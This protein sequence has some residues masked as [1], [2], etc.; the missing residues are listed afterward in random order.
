MDVESDFCV[1]G[2]GP[3]GMTLALLLLRSGGR[4]VVVER[5][6]S[7]D[8]EFRG[9]ILQPG[10]LRLLSE[11]GVLDDARE[12]GCHEHDGFLL[13]SH[14]K[15]L[16]ESDYRRLAPPFNC[17]LSIPQRNILEAL[18]A[19]CE[20]YDSFRYLAGA[21]AR[22]LLMDGQRVRGVVTDGPDG[23]HVVRAHVLIGADGRYSKIRQLA[24]ID[25]ARLDVFDQDIMWF[26]LSDPGHA[27]RHVT[28]FSENGNPAI[29]Y[30]SVP[31]SVQCGWTL[32]HGG[33]SEV[34]GK[35][36]DHI[37]DRLRAA[38]PSYADLIESQVTS[39]RDL[40]LLDV[41][42]GSAAAWV[43]D[44]L[45]LIGDSAHTHSPIGAQGINLAI[46]DAVVLHPLLMAS[47]REG[48]A[49]AAFLG[50]F[51][52]LR[53]RDI[54]RLT[55]IQVAQSRGMLAAGGVAARI[56]PLAAT[57]VT[58]TP[59]YRRMLDLIAFGNRRITVAADLFTATSLAAADLLAQ[60]PP[61]H[62]PVP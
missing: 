18:H 39:L 15:V 54:A 25:F 22:Q 44:G 29:A 9:D 28:V 57:I 20:R 46:Q 38:I 27:P 5:S 43:R 36:I 47:L 42:A 12:R 59:V 4:V 6:R 14:G 1:V 53:R 7:L 11:L 2:G 60:F 37:K 16:M 52:A 50:K 26:K 21:R 48:D 41:F 31:D 51:A 19:H 58:H 45:V 8:R 13:T 49:S 56:R 33:Y 55:R 40:T 62:F 32:P 3:A 10:G 17:L 35:G 34:A 24:G 30:A 23:P 61:E